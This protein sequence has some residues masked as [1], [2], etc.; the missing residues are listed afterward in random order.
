MECVF[1]PVWEAKIPLYGGE[2]YDTVFVIETRKG[3]SKKFE[4]ACCSSK[5]LQN[6]KSRIISLYIYHKK[7]FGNRTKVNFVSF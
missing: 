7:Q 4:N 2:M 1:Y 5:S 3:E 6:A